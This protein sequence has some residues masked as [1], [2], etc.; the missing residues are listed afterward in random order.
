MRPRFAD[1]IR[2]SSP[3]DC[4]NR[5][6]EGGASR[7]SC[8]PSQP[9]DLSMSPTIAARRPAAVDYERTLILSIEVSNQSWVLAAQVPWG[10]GLGDLVRPDLEA[11]QRV[12][13]KVWVI[14]MSA[15][16]RP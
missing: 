8:R 7:I 12:R 16:S 4:V 2:A 6:H 10:F 15:A 1:S 9:G 11:D 13:A 14:G 3:P 5:S